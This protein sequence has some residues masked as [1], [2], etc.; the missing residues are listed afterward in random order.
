M[1]KRLKAMWSFFRKESVLKEMAIGMCSDVDFKRDLH[2]V[3]LDFDEVSLEE[4]E[5]SIIELQQFWNLSDC[6]IYKTRNGHHGYFFYDFMPYSRVKL[7][8]DYAKYVDPM[9]KYISR[10]YD[11]K[12]IRVA[13][14]YKE[15]DIF[16]VKMISGK[17]SPS[18][19]EVE[20]GNLKRKEREALSKM[21]NMLSKGGLK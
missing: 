11:H 3:F 12:T 14:K 8:I 10:F 1:L 9:F 5:E 6:F 2:I 15:H 21:G 13:G 7:I 18:L 4:V 19:K 16:F 20:I 17:R